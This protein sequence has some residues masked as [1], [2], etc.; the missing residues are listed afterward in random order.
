MAPS[1]CVAPDG[2]RLRSSSNGTRPFLD[3]KRQALTAFRSQL[4]T[5]DPE[6]AE[7][8]D[9]GLTP[10][11]LANFTG[12]RELFFPVPQQAGGQRESR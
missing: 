1:R 5:T 3:R 4:A 10:S 7:H 2:E 9:T 8:V 6:E 11:F 12:A